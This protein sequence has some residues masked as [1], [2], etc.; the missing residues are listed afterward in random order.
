MS[1]EVEIREPLWE[2]LAP[3]SVPA[4]TLITK[5]DWHAPRKSGPVEVGEDG[6]PVT[7]W[8]IA[9]YCTCRSAGK[10]GYRDRGDGK[11]VAACCDR[12]ARGV[13]EYAGN[14]ALGGKI[15]ADFEGR[16][17]G[18]G[19]GVDEVGVSM[20]LT[21]GPPEPEYRVTVT[22][23]TTEGPQ[24]LT[25]EGMPLGEA[26]DALAGVIAGVGE[27]FIVETSIDGHTRESTPNGPDYCREC[28]RSVSD[29]ISWPCSPEKV[30]EA[31][32][33]ADA[34]HASAVVLNEQDPTPAPQEPVVDAWAAEVQE[35][36]VASF[37]ALA[38]AIVSDPVTYPPLEVVADSCGVCG[39]P[40]N[41]WDADLCDWLPCPAGEVAAPP[42][43]VAG[44]CEVTELDPSTCAHC[45]GTV[46]PEVEAVVSGSYLDEPTPVSALVAS[47]IQQNPPPAVVVPSSTEVIVSGT[48]GG[49]PARGSVGARGKMKVSNSELRKFKRCRR[50]WW[51]SYYR[52]LTPRK[53]GVGPLSLGN[54][55]HHPLEL[56]YAQPVRDPEAFNWETPLAVYVEA[57]LAD[58]DLPDHLH[59]QMLD[60]YE[61]V[62]IMLR[63]YFEWLA[64]EGADSEIHVLAAER[65]IEA[66]LETIDGVDVWL[67]GK[68]DTEVE[69]KADGR[70]A[71]MDH[72][73]AANMTDLPKMGQKDEQFLTYGLLQRLEALAEGRTEDRFANGGVWNILRK[74][75]RTATAKPPFY[76]RAG[77]S[78]NDEA[79]RNFYARVWGEVRDMLAVRANLDAGGNHH[80][81]A[82]PNPTRDCSW[83][84]PFVS[85]CP[86]FDD[87]SDVESVIEME[88]VTHDPY[89]R[90]EEIEKG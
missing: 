53:D 83:D 19:E 51:L 57:R 27:E 2:A 82:Y 23:E 16:A 48:V 38:H 26:T 4:G 60:D 64:E 59:G 15:P 63:G 66:F 72:K 90:Y 25:S 56:Y 55:I 13:Y 49:L 79:Y 80:V 6:E 42:V 35:A 67:I 30:S 71:F 69:M 3:I 44:L 62:K 84:C 87:G 33:S 40:G 58:P 78:H 12:P 54:M 18:P 21:A 73:S 43:A 75:K 7:E 41:H 68:L 77:V 1:T 8:A 24:T 81:E 28:S 45:L 11:F 37:V 17:F 52:G 39:A 61:L 36:N 31:K 88:F 76:G 89:A 29:W 70:R 65:E 20:V 5:P 9:P 34:F 86:Q 85:I 50:S 46:A 14:E 47:F 22:A 10:L 32:A 74:V